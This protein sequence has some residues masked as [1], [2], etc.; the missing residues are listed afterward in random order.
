MEISRCSVCGEL[1]GDYSLDG[2]Y[3]KY[4]SG[5]DFEGIAGLICSKCVIKHS[6]TDKLYH[7]SFCCDIVDTFEPRVPSNR[8]NE[9]D[10][11]IGRV[12]LSDSIEGCLT[13][14]PNGGMRLEEIFWEGGSS[15]IRIYEFDIKDIEYKNIIPPEYLYQKDLVRD[16]NITREHWVVNKSLTPSKTYLIKLHNYDEG[17]SDDISY[18][19]YI[20][21]VLAENEGRRDFSW[22][23][24]INGS[25]V[26]ILNIKYE[27]VPEERRSSLFRIKNEI[28][29]ISE[30]DFSEIESDIYHS[31]PNIMTWVQLEAIHPG[32]FMITGEID[33][34]GIGEYDTLDIIDYINENLSVGKI[35]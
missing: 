5:E 33:T 29:N 6:G 4:L 11:K 12:C 1:L 21:G 35:I 25:F 9:E 30:D 2:N 14:V 10:S 28:V 13:A 34:R 17:S 27:V 20:E 8:H 18:G 32:K 31:F 3:Y 16:A 22:E 19:D 23:E 26:E 15:L 7:V 24:V